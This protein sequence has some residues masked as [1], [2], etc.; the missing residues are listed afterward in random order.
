[1]NHGTVRVLLIGETKDG[2]SYLRAQLESRGCSCCFGRSTE[3]SVALFD[4]HSFHLILS[5]SPLD[6]GDPYLT[7]LADS[8]CTVYYSRVVE[9]GCWWLPLVRRGQRCWSAPAL[10]PSEFVGVLDHLVKEIGINAERVN[11]LETR[12]HAI[13]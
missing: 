3:E 4:R 8:N 7:E 12:A 6:Y 1:M 5:T 2:S 10:R 11:E 9:N 13:S